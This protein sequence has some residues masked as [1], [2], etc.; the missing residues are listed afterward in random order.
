MANTTIDDGRFSWRL[1]WMTTSAALG[2]FLFGFDSSIINGTVDAIQQAYGLSPAMLGFTVS[3]ALLGAMVGA[4][5]AGVC[6]ERFGR[7]RTMLIAAA[8]LAISALGSGWAYTVWDLIGWRFVGGIGVGFASVIAP[9][10]IV[11]VS[12]AHLRG[13]LGTLQLLSIVIGIFAALLVSAIIARSAGGASASAWFGLAAWRWMFLSELAPAL[14]YAGLALSLPESPRYLVEKSRESE[15]EHV[16]ATVVGIARG[17]AARAKIAEIRDTV[18]HDR[19]KRFGDI[20]SPRYGLLP[21]VWVGIA[22]SVFQQFV[23]INVIFYYSTTLWQSVGFAES[24]SF[25]I[26]VIMALTNIVATFIAIALIDRL[27]RR[28]LLLIGSA[29]MT[30]TLTAMALAFSQAV[31]RDGTLSLPGLWGPIALVA[32]NLYVIGFGASWGPVVWVLLAEMFPNRIRAMALGIG[33]AVQWLAN[34]VVSMTFPILATVGLDAAYGLYALCAFASLLFVWRMV[35]ET[36]GRRLEQMTTK[37]A[38]SAVS[39]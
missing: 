37:K 21:L 16:L 17:A 38:S 5:Y 36:N 18:A 39:V 13:R 33:A 31:M 23:G 7:V 30:I 10:Y 9:A 27:G 1:L 32:G 20:T 22:L 11:E 28:Q 19:T 25:T 8:L 34:F 35:A 12:P 26:S 24:D 3:F 2:G 15:A 29:I 4:W 14:I 6:A